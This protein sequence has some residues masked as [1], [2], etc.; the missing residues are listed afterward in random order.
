MHTNASN[1]VEDVDAIEKVG[2]PHK[3]LEAQDVKDGEVHD[4]VFGLLKE[5]EGAK[6]R[7]VCPPLSP[8]CEYLPSDELAC[9]AYSFRSA[10]SAPRFS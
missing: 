5:G 7:N 1:S 3:G 6:Y 4:A 10:G 2:V 9:Y 8:L